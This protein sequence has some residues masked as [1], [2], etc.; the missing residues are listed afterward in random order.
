[1][2]IERIVRQAEVLGLAAAAACVPV[3]ITVQGIV[4]EDGNCG[5]AYFEFD[6]RSHFGRWYG[7]THRESVGVRRRFYANLGGYQSVDRRT[8]YLKAFRNHLMQHGIS[9]GEVVQVL[10]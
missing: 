3:A 2:D 1:M 9:V 4:Y 6:G 8:A 7:Q 10:D 5:S